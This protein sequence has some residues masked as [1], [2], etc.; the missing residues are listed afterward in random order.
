MGTLGAFE[1][2]VLFAVL[3]LGEDAYGVTIRETLEE[4]TGRSFSSGAIYTA[5]ARLEERGLV[6]SWV[7]EPTP[8]RAGRPPRHYRV[9]PC[10]ARALLDG[11]QEL[12]AMAGG[13][14]AELATLAEGRA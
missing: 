11:Y 3:R 9:E 6:T 10:G 14:V 5:L 4:K 12:Q 8:G 13:V 2:F 7:G 1:Q